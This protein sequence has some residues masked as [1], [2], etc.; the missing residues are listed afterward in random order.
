VCDGHYVNITEE[1]WADVV[2]LIT[3]VEITDTSHSSPL[4]N[5]SNVVAVSSLFFAR[6]S[7][8]T[9]ALTHVVQHQTPTS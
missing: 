4:A 2:A 6:L 1:S 8:W 9:I 7:L 5:H 3:Y